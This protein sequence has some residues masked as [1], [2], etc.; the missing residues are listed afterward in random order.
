V[1]N[2]IYP[3]SIELTEIEQDLLPDLV[4]QD[5]IFQYFPTRSVD[6]A[7]VMWEQLDNY[8]GLQQARGLNGEPTKIQR[9]STKQYRLEPGRYGEWAEIDEM[10]LTLR[11]V[12][13][14]LAAPVNITDLVMQCQ[15]QLLD[16]RI[17]RQK[18]IIW[19]LLTLGVFSVPGPNGAI[20][21]TDA[22]TFQSF[23][24]LVPWSSLGTATPMKDLRSLKLLHRGHSVDFG[25]GAKL[26]ANTTTINNLL[27]NTNTSDLFGRRAMGLS[28]IN[29]LGSVNDLL[30]G[31]NLPTF[32]EYDEG[33]ISDGNF[34]QTKG[35]F[36]TF[37][38]DGVAVLIGQRPGG[39]RVGE[40]QMVRNADDENMAPGPVTKVIDNFNAGDQL[41]PRKVVVYDGH[42]GG[43]A[44]HYPS[45]VVVLSGL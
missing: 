45:A 28:T 32:V 14:D 1:A 43:I 44:I 3:N 8:Q 11:R 37:I 35:Q 23:T 22:Y 27:N 38:P 40:Y 31:D 30:A 29:N 24:P 18:W 21:H 34:G 16:R 39:R 17:K 2:Y 12:P 19:T 26:F 6:A 36:Y 10:E 41:P 33:Y 7:L 13:G 25:A 5:P 9:P 15:N 20:L 4:D 42:A